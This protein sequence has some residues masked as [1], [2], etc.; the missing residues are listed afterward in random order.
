MLGFPST[1]WSMENSKRYRTTNK[2]KQTYY[3]VGS[4]DWSRQ[5]RIIHSANGSLRLE[6]GDV[7]GGNSNGSRPPRERWANTQGLEN[8]SL[9]HEIEQRAQQYR[10]QTK[11][12]V[13]RVG[14]YSQGFWLVCWWVSGDFIYIYILSRAWSLSLV[15]FSE[16]LYLNMYCKSSVSLEGV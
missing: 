12:L 10:V 6:T 16:H 11:A 1:P 14:Y 4:N 8:L 2:A 5:P 3:R 13:P 15:T 7:S 9:G